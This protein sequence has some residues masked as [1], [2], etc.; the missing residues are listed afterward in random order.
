ME[1]WKRQK[2]YEKVGVNT[3]LKN[4]LEV[5]EWQYQKWDSNWEMGKWEVP[6]K[7]GGRLVDS[8]FVG[9][10]QMISPPW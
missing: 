5:G 7:R 1:K 10:G 4:I 3:F 2:N 9:N 8:G 6:K